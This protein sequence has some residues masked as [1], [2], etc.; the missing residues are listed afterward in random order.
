MTLFLRAGVLFLVAATGL[1]GWVWANPPAL[2]V[3]ANRPVDFIKDV[4]PILT[5]RC[6]SCHA[7]AKHRGGLSLESRES[8]LKGGESGPAALEGKSGE[9]LLIKLVAGLVPGKVMPQ[10]GARLS[11]DEIAV[12]RAWIDQG[13]KWDASAIKAGDSWA[14]PLAPRRPDVPTP[15]DDQ[16]STNPIDL[17]L[18]A[19][20]DSK[21]ITPAPPVSDAVYLRRAYLDTIGLLPPTKEAAEF[22]SSTGEFAKDKSP[23]KRAA[24]AQKLLSRNQA[25]AEHWITFWN[26]LLRND[27]QGTGYIDGGRKTI[28]TWLYW[29]LYNNIPYDQFVTQLVNPSAASEGFANGIVWRGETAAAVRPPMQASQNIAKIFLGVNLK[30]ASCHDSFINEWKLKDSYGL[31]N[32]YSDAP[33]EL[34]RCDIPT[35]QKAETKFLWPELGSIDASRPRTGRLAQLALLITKEENGRTPRTIVNRLWAQYFGRGL[36]EPLDD[37]AQQPWSADLLDWLASDLVSNGYDLK[38]I[39]QL[40]VTSRAYQLPSVATDPRQ[41]LPAYVFKGPEVRRLT[42]EE[43]LDGISTLTGVWQASPQFAIPNPEPKSD[44]SVVRAWRVNSDALTRALGRP[45]RDNVTTRRQSEATTLQA[46]ELTNGPALTD[47]LKRGTEKLLA[48]NPQPSR[49]RVAALYTQ[50]ILRTPSEKE[51]ELATAM[52]G[53]PVTT[54]SLEDFLWSLIM[55]PEFQYVY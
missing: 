3:A 11:S 47:W 48:T 36:V 24:L 6:Y 19:Y 44:P 39:M 8:L 5:E 42:A 32:V 54:D 50:A 28:T 4:H 43:I 27:F 33:L 26:D 55:T 9:S 22:L 2:P 1:P 37:M 15:K 30:C 12:L 35:G 10:S 31:A 51:M 7:G 41:P 14:A 40:I 52:V 45:N 46:L 17:F 25:Y 49:D 29:A 16:A 21:T 13:L 23:D 53:D 34:V 20:F 38:H 18:Q